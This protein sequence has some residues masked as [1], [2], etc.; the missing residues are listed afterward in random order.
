M[1]LWKFRFLTNPGSTGIYVLTVGRACGGSKG[2]DRTSWERGPTINVQLIRC[3][4]GDSPP[5]TP[6]GFHVEAMH[7]KDKRKQEF[8]IA[9]I[10]TILYRA[11]I[12]TTERSTTAST[13]R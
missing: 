13:S 7:D 2:A 5:Q 8:V 12:K 9:R 6:Y 11:G 3:G 4:L 10:D 1:S